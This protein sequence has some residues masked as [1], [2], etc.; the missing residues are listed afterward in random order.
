MFSPHIFPHLF[1]HIFSQL[2][3]HNLPNMALTFNLFCILDGHT[4]SSSFSVEVA[5]GATVD[6]LK[7]SI[8]ARMSAGLEGVDS[9]T[10]TLWKVSI[11]VTKEDMNKVISLEELTD[12]EVLLPTTP[13]RV[14]FE[15]LKEGQ[16]IHIF[17]QCP[18][19]GP[20]QLMLKI[21]FP[22]K[23]Q[24]VS[25][26]TNH[27][28]VLLEELKTIVINNHDGIDIGNVKISIQHR[29]RLCHASSLPETP[30]TDKDLRNILCTYSKRGL[31]TL[32]VRVPDHIH[33][34][35]SRRSASFQ[36]RKNSS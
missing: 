30:A 36:P 32:S 34:S 3:P 16:F 33:R 15:G 24:K 18:P 8:K 6:K 25:W 22:E 5:L 21:Y 11:P 26:T 35:G 19:K 31:G 4:V 23:K 20:S 2:F 7:E 14:A 29:R 28:T 27:T 9:N 17:V 10:L 12:K 13:L 1:S